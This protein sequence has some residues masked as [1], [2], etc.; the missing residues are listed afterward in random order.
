MFKK[1]KWFIIR[2]TVNG[3]NFQ[4]IYSSLAGNLLLKLPK[5]PNNFGIQSVNSNLKKKLVFL[6]IGIRKT[7]TRKIPTQKFPTWN[8]PT[9]IFKHSHP[10]Y[11]FPDDFIFETSH[12]E[13]DVTKFN[14]LN[15]A[16]WIRPGELSSVLCVCEYFSKP[17][18]RITTVKGITTIEGIETMFCFWTFLII[19]TKQPT[20][21]GLKIQKWLD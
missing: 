11:P 21:S 16:A 5:P 19:F 7:P 18:I 8:I 17:F 14:Q 10:S 9:H 1:Q 20:N 15:G 13:S 3:R 6:N 12:E 4:N 2:S